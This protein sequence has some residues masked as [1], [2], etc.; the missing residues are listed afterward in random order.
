MAEQHV[1]TSLLDDLR[2]QQPIHTALCLGQDITVYSPEAIN[3]QYFNASDF[4]NLP[5]TQ[6]YDLAVVVLHE[7]TVSDLPNEQQSQLIVKLRDLM[8]KRLIVI[9]DQKQAQQLRALGLTQ[10]LNQILD[11]EQLMVWQFNI[12]NY[13]QVPDWLNSRFW[14]NP[15]HWNKFR[16]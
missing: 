16:W 7:Q 8:A 12:L 1:L 15:E 10:M 3:W 11:D 5:F 14:A 6:R 4:L 13:K 2:Q 9:A